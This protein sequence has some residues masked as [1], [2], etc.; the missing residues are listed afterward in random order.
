[1]A[2]NP[3]INK[4]KA[5]QIVNLISIDMNVKCGSPFCPYDELVNG[6]DQAYWISGDHNPDSF[7]RDEPFVYCSKEC[8][9]QGYY[10]H[11][12]FKAGQQDMRVQMQNL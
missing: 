11:L 6:E 8:A 7:Y 10:Y 5:Y 4:C 3:E 9:T 2:H 12:G 1:M